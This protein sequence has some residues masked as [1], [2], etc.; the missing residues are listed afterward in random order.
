[1]SKPKLLNYVEKQNKSFLV[2]DDRELTFMIEFPQPTSSEGLN[3][4]D[5]PNSSFANDVS[6]IQ[7]KVNHNNHNHKHKKTAEFINEEFS[8]QKTINSIHPQI[9]E[10]V[11]E[12]RSK[13]SND[14][15]NGPRLNPRFFKKQSILKDKPPKI[16]A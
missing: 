2:Q 15:N 13:S 10:T 4:F 3:N 6:I 16:E 7:H 11:E 14:F 12:R 9:H 8:S 5:R 1:M